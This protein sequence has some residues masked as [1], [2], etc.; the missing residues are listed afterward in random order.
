M[1]VGTGT[2]P[3]SDAW[4]ISLLMCF[5]PSES[6]PDRAVSSGDFARADDLQASHPHGLLGDRIQ[7]MCDMHAIGTAIQGRVALWAAD[8]CSPSKAV[9]QRPGSMQKR[10][11]KC[12]CLIVCLHFVH[13]R[14]ESPGE[15]SYTGS[16]LPCA[17]AGLP[18]CR[19]KVAHMI[20]RRL[21]GASYFEIS[22]SL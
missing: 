20:S 8:S 22:K 16:G 12:F 5:S 4:P 19:S 3:R 21:H 17:L 13:A 10:L 14:A 9:G 15:D 18:V 6:R 1:P 11:H 7:H 2:A